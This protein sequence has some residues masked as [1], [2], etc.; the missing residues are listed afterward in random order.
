MCTKCKIGWIDAN[1]Q[2]TYDDNVAIGRVRIAGYTR[3]FHGRLL[4]F[5]TSEWFPI[6]ASHANQLRMLDMD[7]WEF[8]AWYGEDDRRYFQGF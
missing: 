2:P 6:C 7:Q 1:A 5:P 8:D 4:A 3:M